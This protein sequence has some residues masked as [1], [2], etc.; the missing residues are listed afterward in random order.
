MKCQAHWQIICT[1]ALASI[2]S[3]TRGQQAQRFVSEL[4]QTGCLINPETNEALVDTE[5]LYSDDEVN[6]VNHSLKL[7]SKCLRGCYAA[8]KPTAPGGRSLIRSLLNLSL[9]LQ[10]VASAT[11]LRELN[12]I[13]KGGAHVVTLISNLRPISIA[14][15]LAAIQDGLFLLRHRRRLI[16]YWGPAQC[17]GVYEALAC[18][19]CLVLLGENRIACG[20]PLLLG[21]GDIQYGFDVAARQDMLFGCFSAGIVG[22]FWM[23]I[24][25]MFRQDSCR[26]RLQ[27]LVSLEQGT[28]Q[29]R[30]SSVHLFSCQMKLLYDLI[31]SAS[32][33]VAA[34]PSR[35][36]T[37]VL[38][39]ADSLARTSTS[40]YGKN[41]A[42]LF[43]Q[44]LGTVRTDIRSIAQLVSAESSAPLRLA[45]L[46]MLAQV[47]LIALQYIDDIE[48]P[49]SSAE[50]L[51]QNWKACEAFYITPRGP[52]QHWAAQVCSTADRRHNKH[53]LRQRSFQVF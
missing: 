37:E 48:S 20:L 2:S 9:F 11:T 35:W 46:D 22:R 36:A 53:S 31:E 3:P 10:L 12:P 47:I 34:W 8:V 6:E 7:G 15:E 27:D 51:R 42:A 44:S 18:V 19:L 4:R 1:N 30:R 50:Q 32:S 52:I 28:A 21:F 33:G 41:A 17:G 13:R 45:A 5:P 43:G 16:S 38:D 29:G 24:D 23:L 49:A 39:F 40:E 26:V 25:D 14:S